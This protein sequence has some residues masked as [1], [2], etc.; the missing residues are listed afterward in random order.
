MEILRFMLLGIGTGSVYAMLA[1]GLVLVY[2]GSGLLN[3]SQGA[4]AMVGAFAYY[5]ATSEHNLPLWLGVLIALVIC[6]VLGA[7][8]HLL[9]LRQMQRSSALSRVIATL[10]IMIAL[11][12]GAY[13]RYGH[14]PLPVKSI[15]PLT[16]VHVFSDKL[17]VGE[18]VLAIFGIGLALTIVLTLVYKRTSFG[19]ITTAVAE[20]QRVA[21]TLGHSPDLVASVNWALGAVI[22]G[23]GGIL[24]API[25]FLEPTQ[26]VLLVLPAMSAALLGGFTSFPIV[27]IMAV[28]LGIAQSLIG[29]Y[30]SQAGW[31]SAAPFFVVVVVLIL[32]GQVLPLR[33]HVL[34][35][36]P[37]VG[38]GRIRWRAVFV[39]YALGAYLTLTANLDWALA[40]ITTLSL[41]VICV[42]IVIVT[43]YAGQ[44][45]LAQTV[46]AGI[47]VLIA[48]KTAGHVPFLVSL[49]I[50]AAGAMAAGFLV[51]IPALRTRGVTL[52]IATLGLGT[53]LTSV[54]LTNTNFT[55]GQGGI[56]VTNQSIFGWNINPLFESNR[57]AFV[58]FT[59][60]VL[61]CIAVANLR[62]GSTGRQL[63]ALRSNERA[64]ASLGLP[65]SVLKAYAFVLASAIAGVGGVLF[66]FAQPTVVFNGTTDNFSVFASILVV[67]MTVAGG[68][69][70][71][72]GALIGSL[73]LAGG[74][75]S[76][77]L[78]GWSS[79]NDY[80][81]LI[82]GIGLVLTLMQGQDGI[83]EYNRAIL[84]RVGSK[85]APF[86]P[87]IPLPRIPLPRNRRNPLRATETS[88]SVTPAVL[89]VRGL[90]VSFGGINAVQDVD[91]VVEPGK[92]H[93]LIG[94]NGAG[95]T[96]FIDAVTGFVKAR[97]SVMLGSV[98][99]SDLSARARA[100]LGISRSFQ[101]LELFNDL[102]IRENLVVACERRHPFRYVTDLFWPGRAKLSAAAIE[103]VRQFELADIIERRPD[104]ISFGRRK[105]VAI[106]RAIAA[107]P[108]VLLLDE[109]AAGL[110]DHEAVELARLIR[111]VA[112]EWNIGVLLVEHK[113]DLVTSISDTITVLE[114]GR[115]LAAGMAQDVVTSQVVIDA[116]LGTSAPIQVQS[117]EVA[118]GVD[119]VA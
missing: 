52:A 84:A 17:G 26:L 78:S 69:G 11:Q 59:V 16:T 7:L 56:A 105:T 2:R 48:A 72:G 58:S 115:V 119:S 64:A 31:A 101:S 47:G 94:P 55:N 29:Q 21:A 88:V 106:A 70:S 35:R 15:I 74:I 54:V 13:L 112:D 38:S 9:V 102:T 113:V 99:L 66:A 53:A 76:Q 71:V 1:Q 27:F 103:A 6:G 82:G 110:N 65:G 67:A 77:A 63:I 25:L 91:L 33:S 43:G 4:I 20:K 68:V 14:D 85:V 50:G 107:A 93:G 109:P 79:I 36:L 86:L 96:T 95:K 117:D 90:S 111:M 83:F 40:M 114:S 116:Y 8:I 3:F 61:I 45:N 75:I 108:P 87:R 118:Q 10:G 18:N 100:R 49:L 81:P 32:R 98:E 23:L 5:E 12:A 60:L 51:G 42:S 104:S 46:I 89:T 44:L 30:V 73:L 62:R 19:R 24:I 97:G 37:R 22:A 28:L 41:A 57:Y 80:L 92:V 39:L 34:D